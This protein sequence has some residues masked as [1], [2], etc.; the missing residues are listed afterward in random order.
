MPA[1]YDRMVWNPSTMT[2]GP[3]ADLTPVERNNIAKTGRTSRGYATIGARG[4]DVAEAQRLLGIK[5]DGIF[6][7]DTLRAVKQAQAAAGLVTDGIIGPLTLQTLRQRGT[8]GVSSTGTANWSSVGTSPSAAPGAQGGSLLKK[9]SF[10]LI[11][12][13]LAVLAA[14]LKAAG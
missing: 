2:T 6:G 5:A 14:K 10:W 7:Q 1:T 9:P 8:Q 3:E 11:L 13:A 12:G 4:A